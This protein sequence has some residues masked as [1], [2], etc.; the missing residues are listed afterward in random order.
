[1]PRRLHTRRWRRRLD[2]IRSLDPE[3][4]CHEIYYAMARE[5]FRVDARI[6]QLLAFWR[7]VGVPSIAELLYSTGETTAR[8]AKRADDTGIIMYELIDHGF[9]HPRG[10]LA[11]RRLNELHR[12]FAIS[13]DDYL[14]VLGSLVVIPTRWV[15]RHGWR[16]LCCHE[17]RATYTFYRELGRRMNIRGIPADYDAFAAWFDAYEREHFAYTEAAAALTRSTKVIV[18]KRFPAPAAAIIRTFMTA[19]LDAPLRAATGLAEPSRLA[20]TG[21]RAALAVRA[22][23]QR[24]RPPRPLPRRGDDEPL[25]APSYPDGY[26]LATVGPDGGASGG[27]A[28]GS[29]PPAVFGGTE[30]GVPAELGAEVRRG[31]E[32][33]GPRHGVEA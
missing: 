33:A 14:Y 13:N 20:S 29:E 12:R 27:V 32:P 22:R 8:P 17:R 19:L 30:P 5:D 6:G 2:R 31:A 24:L 4:D 3:R 28:G 26:D 23:L 10:R 11:I 15:E 21:L 18:D 1:M 16:P 25:R 9:D 7:V